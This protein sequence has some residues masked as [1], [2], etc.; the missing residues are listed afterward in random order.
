MPIQAAIEY[1]YR[2][3]GKDKT[4]AVDVETPSLNVECFYGWDFH[5]APGWES[6]KVAMVKRWAEGTS[7]FRAI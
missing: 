5:N 2:C 4:S 3:A 1:K 7:F 6:A